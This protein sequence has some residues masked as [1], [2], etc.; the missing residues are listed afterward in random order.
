MRF[1]SA[2]NKQYSPILDLH[3][4][5]SFLVGQPSILNHRPLPI[6]PHGPTS[7]W[8]QPFQLP[9]SKKPAV[10]YFTVIVLMYGHVVCCADKHTSCYY[11]E[12]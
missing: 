5:P 3:P 7:I 12:W 2:S 4:D 10:N 6:V 1:Q 11:G 8:M 9:L